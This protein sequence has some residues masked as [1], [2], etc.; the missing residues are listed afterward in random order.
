MSLRDRIRNPHPYGSFDLGDILAIT[1]RCYIYPPPRAVEGITRVLSYM[2]RHEGGDMST[3]ALSHYATVYAPVILEQHPQLRDVGKPP[4]EEPPNFGSRWD[5]RE[6]EAEWY[7][8][9]QARK[10]K[11]LAEQKRQYGD[12]LV[13]SVPPRE[14][15]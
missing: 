1:T 13:L 8:Q 14:N 11:W 15:Q 12:R 10:D 9:L 3:L 5:A 4:Y 6:R 2:S 7:E